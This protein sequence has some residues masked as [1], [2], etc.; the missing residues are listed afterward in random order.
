MG[1][2]VI[3]VVGLLNNWLGKVTETFTDNLNYYVL[4]MTAN[5]FALHEKVCVVKKYLKL[6]EVAFVAKM[7]KPSQ[8]QIFE[9]KPQTFSF[10][11]KIY[12]MFLTI[13]KSKTPWSKDTTVIFKKTVIPYPS[14]SQ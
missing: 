12:S 9:I 3:F 5:K 11:L 10:E 4:Q 2:L 1:N 13:L 6:A 14:F 7:S 8:M